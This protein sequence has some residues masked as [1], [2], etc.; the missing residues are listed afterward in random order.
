MSPICGTTPARLEP[1]EGQNW[2]KLYQNCKPLRPVASSARF[3]DGLSKIKAPGEGCHP[4]LLSAANFAALDGIDPGEAAHRI[5]ESIPPGNRRVAFREV[6]VAVEKAYKGREGARTYTPPPRAPQAQKADTGRLWGDCVAA[7]PEDCDALCELTES[8]PFR[9]EGAPELDFALLLRE[10]FDGGDILYSGGKKEIAIPGRNLQPVRDWIVHVEAG[11]KLGAHFTFNPLSGR[12]GMT[13]GGKPSFRA[14]NCVAAWRFCL[15]EF[16]KT[17][18][19]KQAA[20]WLRHVDRL[21]VAA[22]IHSGGKSLHALLEVNCPD[23]AAWAREVKPLY[24]G[25]LRDL[26]ADAAC[27]NPARMSRTP[28]RWRTDYESTPPPPKERLQKLVWLRGRAHG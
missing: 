16:D 13:A 11:G 15:V 20:F 5:F 12:E 21:N 22:I 6:A 10:R 7:Y 4:S 18:V 8:S 2:N 14:D 27:S 26:G 17:P 23:A 19:W 1:G 25:I 24:A 9:L 28:G 3:E